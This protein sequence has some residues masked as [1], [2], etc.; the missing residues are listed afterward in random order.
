MS[1]QLLSLV[2]TAIT[3]AAIA[4]GI[5]QL[6]FRHSRALE[7]E[8]WRRDLYALLIGGADDARVAAEHTFRTREAPEGVWEDAISRMNRALNEILLVAPQMLS[9]AEKL[10]TATSDLLDSR[11]LVD[12]VARDT[13]WDELEGAY[14]AAFFGFMTAA[15]QDLA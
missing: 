8:R 15:R 6:T 1:D 10:V 3:S 5:T 14:Y 9:P 11:S 12:T 7:H 13:R 2:V 4:I